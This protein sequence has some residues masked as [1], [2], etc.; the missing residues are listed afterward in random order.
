MKPEQTLRKTNRGRAAVLHVMHAHGPLRSLWVM[1]GWERAL[2]L[3]VYR[4]D[5]VHLKQ[6]RGRT[7]WPSLTAKAIDYTS[8]I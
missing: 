6:G 5:F 8:E 2:T 4:L 7:R 3:R 1:D